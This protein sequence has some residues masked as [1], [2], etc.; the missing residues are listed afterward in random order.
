MLAGRYGAT[1]MHD[2]VRYAALENVERAMGLQFTE[3]QIQ[4]AAQGGNARILAPRRPPMA[5]PKRKQNVDTET[6]RTEAQAALQ[7]I[8]TEIVEL[9]AKRLELDSQTVVAKEVALAAARRDQIRRIELLDH[10]AAEELTE[11]QKKSQLALIGRVEAKLAERD[12]AR[13]E[14]AKHLEAA[15]IAFRKAIAANAAA[16]AA[17]P[18]AATDMQACLIGRVFVSQVA[19][20]IYRLAGSPFVRG[21]AVREIEFA[22]RRPPRAGA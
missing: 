22:V 4:S 11:R 17:W 21:D 2:R 13:T 20:E 3:A 16:S 14:V 7:E 5:V 18:W 12:E 1:F 9:D 15:V 10:R 6:L 19:F 8:D